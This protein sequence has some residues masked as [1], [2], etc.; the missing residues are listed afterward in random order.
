MNYDALSTTGPSGGPL[1]EEGVEDVV[2]VVEEL[3]VD[4]PFDTPF[5]NVF[6]ME[7][8]TLIL[9]VPTFRNAKGSLQIGLMVPLPMQISL[10]FSCYLLY[11][12]LGHQTMSFMMDALH[13]NV[14]LTSTFLDCSLTLNHLAQRFPMQP[15]FQKVGTIA[16]PDARSF[17]LVT[18]CT[19]SMIESL[20][21]SYL[22]ED[23]SNLLFPPDLNDP[24]APPPLVVNTLADIY[25]GHIYQGAY[26][27]LC[28]GRPNHVLCGIILYIDKLAVDCHGHLSLEPVYFTL[29]MFKNPQQTT[30]LASL[31]IHTEH[32]SNVKS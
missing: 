22:M 26:N 25:T 32:W 15:L 18:H 9:V 5:A 21:T 24:L 13:H 20:L 17:P 6:W 31:G 12:I 29:S 23:D 28:R 2:E 8:R 16:S 7:L 27:L 30:G 10:V 1:R 11:D 14:Y 19:K 3:D 4:D